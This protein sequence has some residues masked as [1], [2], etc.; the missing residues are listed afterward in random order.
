MAPPPY[1][2]G[3]KEKKEFN[4]YVEVKCNEK[5]IGRE[6]SSSISEE[7]QNIVYIKS[8][9]NPHDPYFPQILNR[10]DHTKMHI[11]CVKQEAK[12]SGNKEKL[13]VGDFREVNEGDGW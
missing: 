11:C 2:K 7:V 8:F 5:K 6:S 12:E 9:T 10:Y 4:N 1:S 13:Q 3:R